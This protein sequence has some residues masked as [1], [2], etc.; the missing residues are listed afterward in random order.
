MV[1]FIRYQ[2]T[3]L[4]TCSSNS[5]GTGGWIFAAINR[6]PTADEKLLPDGPLTL[7]EALVWEAKDW[8]GTL[9]Y[10]ATEVDQATAHTAQFVDMIR[11]I[12]A[13]TF[14]KQGGLIFLPSLDYLDADEATIRAAI[15]ADDLFV[16]PFSRSNGTIRPQQFFD[17]L[18]TGVPGVSASFN[19]SVTFHVPPEAAESY[20]QLDPTGSST[21]AVSLTGPSAPDTAQPDDLSARLWF[22]GPASGAFRFGLTIRQ[23]SLR[24]DLNMG[25]QLLIPNPE[26][27]G[28]DPSVLPYLP[29]YL[30]LAAPGSVNIFVEFTGQVNILNPNNAVA[31]ASE[32]AFI[33]GD[34]MQ[35]GKSMPTALQSCYRTNFGKTVLLT[36]LSET[37]SPGHA[38]RLVIALGGQN[39]PLQNGFRFG[40]AG[41]FAIGV[42][43]AKPN[44]SEAILCGQSGTETVSVV[45]APGGT[46]AQQRLRFT[47]GMPAN[48]PVF[49]LEPVSPVGPPIDPKA[50]LMDTGFTTSWVSF[51]ADPAA[52][53]VA[54]GHYAAMPKGAELFGGGGSTGTLGPKD[55]GVALPGTREVFFPMMP[56]SGFVGSDGLQDMTT[57]D[58]ELLSRQIV[59]P[60]RKNCINLAV[61]TGA[62][63]LSA[64]ALHSLNASVAR[65]AL[66][67]TTLTS[68]TTPT[69]FITR[70]DAG[71]A[72]KQLLLAQVVTNG[73]VTRQMGFTDLN[74]NL[75]AAFQTTDQFLVIANNQNLGAFTDPGQGDPPP[76][77]F[78]PPASPEIADQQLFFNRINIGQWDFTTKPGVNNAYG[79]YASVMIVK[80]VKGKILDIDSTGKVLPGSLVKSPDKWTMKDTFA[81][82]DPPDM[83]ELIPL[84]DWLVEYCTDA[85]EQ[86]A[87]DRG[88]N[89]YFA[90]FVDI[91]TD[92]DWTG[93][94]ILKAA[95]AEVP[96]DI[97]GILAGVKDPTDFYAHHVGFDIGQ[98][99]KDKV[100]QT[101][102]TS[103]FGLVYY[104]DPRY[105]DRPP[106]HTIQPANLEA[107]QDFTLLTLKALFENSAISKFESL[108][109]MV[110]NR[111]FGAEVTAMVD[112]KPE[113]REENPDNA[114]LLQGGV[115]R[116]GDSVVYSLTSRWPN[117]YSLANNVLTSV[118]ID[119][120]SM[121]TRDTGETSGE[122]VSWIGMSGF[123]N[124]SVV[125]GDAD[126]DLP[127][128]DV[129]SYGPESADSNALRQ[130]LNFSNLGLRIAT[131]VAD[132]VPVLT[133]VESEIAF[134]SA[135][136]HARD[137][138]LYKSFQLELLGLLSGDAEG[139]DKSD[140]ASLG[141]LPALT[142]Y[143][144]RGVSG[145]WHGL[146]FKLNLGTPGALAG[147][148]NLDSSMLIAWSDDSGASDPDSY[149]AVVGIALP[150]AGGGGELFSLQTVLKLSIGLVQLFYAP[151]DGANQGGF[152]LVLNQIA[153]KFLG[154]LKVPP[155]GNTAFMLFGDPDAGDSTGL[156]WFAVY[157]K[158]KEEAAKK[159]DA[160]TDA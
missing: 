9:V 4:Y 157:N 140:P 22:D 85:W 70:Y 139:A 56:L 116:N 101:E 31:G 53:G 130:G 154:L 149:G 12:L 52:S 152:L 123:M 19:P 38:G 27:T 61:S 103:M 100:E 108:A 47:G 110:L 135:D 20:I 107:E 14:G 88:N 2:D 131:P 74:D 77:F 153:L 59:G 132:P 65:A 84:S 17:V 80:G 25:F 16:V 10:L 72:W 46:T 111:L 112:V 129:F 44:G 3:R 51:L 62:A 35:N 92:P 133:L 98:I 160:K 145:R 73:S 63:R 118:E 40:P 54:G 126:A 78:A 15:G 58:L 11:T 156:G 45:I 124:F 30:P 128:F 69:G 99:S 36:P 8:E 155:S 39:T 18:L 142:Q 82:P 113:G 41:D 143:D 95:I 148:V 105:D 66:A 151:P 21:P 158:A 89:P 106:A 42:A 7:T 43:G 159:A 90:K 147:K 57:D 91:I 34:S 86:G 60:T 33:F 5:A 32:T 104:V 125:P 50:M 137:K 96:S 64:S 24:T 134:N 144:L 76:H 109:Q 87:P 67:D 150:G 68:T 122:M 79:D 102:T 119:T 136:S 138:S 29:A 146:R 117:Q 114:V 115:Q 121:S 49:P 97:S 127:D 48:A 81:T 37:Q 83:S 1:Q 141:F 71:G 120:A 55:P 23:P 6:T 94:L 13:T 28:T 75:Q 26:S 93:V